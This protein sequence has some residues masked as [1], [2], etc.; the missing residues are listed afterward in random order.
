ML[1]RLKD[2]QLAMVVAKLYDSE[3][4][5][6]DSFKQ[7]LYEEIL[8]YDFLL[9]IFCMCIAYITKLYLFVI[10][11]D[12]DGSNHDI[13]RAHPDP[14]LRSMAL[15]LLKDYSGSLATLLISRG[16]HLHS[17]YEESATASVSA[18]GVPQADPNVFNFY[19]YLRTHPLLVRQFVAT[20]VHI[21]FSTFFLLIFIFKSNP[22]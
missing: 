20:Q 18:T 17:A 8:G 21:L 15:W 9:F 7:L 22:I 2:L 1:T 6:P 16:G 13:A 5:M 3:V 14:F 4:Q 12:A 10:R 11:C 19:V